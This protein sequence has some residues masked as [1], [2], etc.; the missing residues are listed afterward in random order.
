MQKKVNAMKFM[1]DWQEK[2]QT[3]V[4]SN[5]SEST[6]KPFTVSGSS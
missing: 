5:K 3:M 6:S 2:E 4:F 1:A